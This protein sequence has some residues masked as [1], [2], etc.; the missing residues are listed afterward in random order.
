[1]KHALIAMASGATFGAGL[2]LA[3]MTRPEK[4]AAFLDVAGDWDPS[5]ALVMVAAIAVHA[6]GMRLVLRRGRPLFDDAFHLPTRRLL[7][8][9]LVLGTAIFGVGW[10][11][12]GLCPGPALVSSAALMPCALVF[13]VTMT[14]GMRLHAAWAARADARD[15]AEGS[16]DAR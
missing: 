11:L 7:D 16:A 12:G 2:T 3:G 15:V 14:L 13:V 8:G 10:G 5:L 6:T 4:V 9:R 1:M